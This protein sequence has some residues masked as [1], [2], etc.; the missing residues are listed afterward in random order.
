[1]LLH[2]SRKSARLKRAPMLKLTRYSVGAIGP[3]A[4]PA[5]KSAETGGTEHRRSRIELRPLV[6][7]EDPSGMLITRAC[8]SR[9]KWPA[10]SPI[11]LHSAQLLEHALE[12][13]TAKPRSRFSELP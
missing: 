13:V 11:Y 8:L 7:A 3:S 4:E 10:P 6:G 12:L 2:S 1:M 5:K 9:R